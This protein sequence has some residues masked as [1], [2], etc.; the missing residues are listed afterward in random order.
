MQDLP[1]SSYEQSHAC[2][3]K[4]LR[5]KFLSFPDCHPICLLRYFYYYYYFYFY[6]YFCF[7]HNRSLCYWSLIMIITVSIKIF[8]FADILVPLLFVLFL[9]NMSWFAIIFYFLCLFFTF[10]VFLFFF[11]FVFLFVLLC[12]VFLFTL[13]K[14]LLFSYET[15]KVSKLLFFLLLGLKS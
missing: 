10:L 7:S 9:L 5:L 12:L 4:I 3:M 8:T 13:I 14:K 1:N 11:V 2:I 6:Y 15:V